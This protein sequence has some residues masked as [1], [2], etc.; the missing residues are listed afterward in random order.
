MRFANLYIR[1]TVLASLILAAA[2]CQTAQKPASLLPPGSAPSL[3]PAAPAPGPSAAAT[4]QPAAPEADETSS[5]KPASSEAK[6]A[7]T[8]STQSSSTPSS[9]ASDPV[10][11]L[12]A[13]V[14]KEYQ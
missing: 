14:E 6:P 1:S 11:D 4:A 3:K 7:Q 2:G 12:I 8:S 9:A 13:R 5:Q 10:A